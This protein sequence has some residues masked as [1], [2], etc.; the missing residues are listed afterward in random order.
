MSSQRTHT[1]QSSKHARKA[2]PARFDI[3]NSAF[4]I[5]PVRQNCRNGT[6]PISFKDST[7]LKENDH[8]H[9]FAFVVDRNQLNPSIIAA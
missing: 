2:L 4:A 5:R 9:K 3:R 8:I 7:L 1:T 6:A